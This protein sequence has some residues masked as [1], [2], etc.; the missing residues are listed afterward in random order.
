MK[1]KL[2]LTIF[3]ISL[4]ALPFGCFEFIVDFVQQLEKGGTNKNFTTT[5]FFLL[6]MATLILPVVSFR[7]LIFARCPECK[8][9][10]KILFSK[11]KYTCTNCEYCL[12]LSP[13][14]KEEEKQNKRSGTD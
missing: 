14:K 4:Y 9:T 11:G 5:V 10:T 7:Y 12:E 3:I 2:H 8:S 1:P 6:M 13:R